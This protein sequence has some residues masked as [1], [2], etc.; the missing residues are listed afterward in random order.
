MNFQAI[1]SL[2]MTKKDLICW[3]ETSLTKNEVT[4]QIEISNK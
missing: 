2:Y 4:D 3:C 1:V